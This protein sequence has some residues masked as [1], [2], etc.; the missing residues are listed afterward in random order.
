MLSGLLKG[1]SLTK[2]ASLPHLK[3]PL[4]LMALMEQLVIVVASEWGATPKSSALI[5]LFLVLLYRVTK[6]VFQVLDLIRPKLIF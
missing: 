2:W 4:S 1:Q 5:F 6:Y 3:Q